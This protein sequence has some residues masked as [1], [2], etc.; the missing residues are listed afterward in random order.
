VTPWACAAGSSTRED[1]LIA[2]YVP[3][4]G[5]DAYA[6]AGVPFTFVDIGVD[7]L[8]GT[9]DDRNLTMLG[10][11][12]ANAATDFPVTR[13][14]M[15]LPQFGRYKTIEVSMNKRYGDRWSGSMGYSWTL[16]RNFANGYPQNP[17]QPFDE[18]RTLWSWKATASYDARWGVRITPVLRHQ[19][20][21]NFART[22]IITVPAGSGLFVT[23]NNFFTETSDANR[24][25]DV[26][27]F[28]ARLEKTFGIK[29]NVRLRGL[30]DFFNITNSHAAE[31]TTRATGPTYL[32]PVAIVAP[33]TMRV[34]FR[35][36]W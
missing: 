6:R 34:G 33:F 28:D 3:G 21:Q 22:G 4:R 1:D 17:N 11:P 26:W 31:T 18:D 5:L 2:P 14:V 36:M 10:L 8:R 35:F 23:G 30:L 20:G 7:G 12:S 25:D 29:G 13:V 15:N 24:E 19:S 32:R 9:T 16:G 27:V